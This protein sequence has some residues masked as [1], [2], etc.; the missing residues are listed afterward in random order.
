[1][2]NLQDSLV[3]IVEFPK[4]EILTLS[5]NRINGDQ[6]R[7]WTIFVQKLL[8]KTVL[9]IISK[10]NHRLNFP[11][12]WSEICAFNRNFIKSLTQEHFLLRFDMKCQ[13]LQKLTV[14]AESQKISSLS[15]NTGIIFQPL[16]ECHSINWERK[17]KWKKFCA[18]N[19]K[20]Y[21]L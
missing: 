1:M 7:L 2:N 3:I 14:K 20:I 9:I 8:F 15:E 12:R 19:V 21:N 6:L 16:L 10:K 13:K 5:S 18:V 11:E 17:R 4:L